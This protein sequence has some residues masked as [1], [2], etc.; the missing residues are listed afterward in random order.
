MTAKKIVKFY[1]SWCGPCKIYGKTW[2]KVI[3]DYK[4]QIDFLNVDVDKDTSGLAAKYKIESIP[5]TVLI[6]EDGSNLIKQ[7]RLS[8]E[9]LTELILS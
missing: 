8:K 1:A 5:T 6:R 4:D 2:D 3:P 9:E 7:G